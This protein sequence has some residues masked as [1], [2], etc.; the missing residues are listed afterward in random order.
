[1]IERHLDKGRIDLA[2]SKP[3]GYGAEDRQLALAR[4][5]F[6]GGIGLAQKERGTYWAVDEQFG[7][8]LREL[9]ARN[10][11]IAQLYG[12]L[13]NEAGRVERMTGAEA[14]IPVA[15]I[16]I[17][18]GSADEIGDDRFVVLRDGAGQA[19]YGRVRDTEAYRDLRVGSVAE[20][21]AGA[22]RRQQIAE[23]V[24]AV[25]ADKGLYSAEL[26]QAYLRQSQPDATERQI[27]S[28]VRSAESRL[29]FVAG[30]ETSGVRAL[31]G[32]QYAVDVEVFRQ[33]SQ[34]GSERT[35]V[36]VIAEHTLTNQIEA[37]AATWLDRQAFG[38]H[39][40]PRTADHP[41]VQDAIAQRG[42]WLVREGYAQRS[43]GDEAAVQLRG[44]ALRQLESEER[45]SLS[46]RLSQ[47]HGLPVTE[48][49]Q[50]GTVDG[51][52]AGVEHLH[53]GKMAVVVA[54]EGVFISPVR[55]AP[56]AA[57]GSAVTLERTSAQDSTVELAASQTLDLEAGMSLDGP[58]GD[59]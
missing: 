53:A 28:S 20:L 21:G 58:G 23:Q 49:P 6:L 47:K 55:Q 13:G 43:Q 35:D 38:D 41:A 7:R 14:S 24:I 3:I 26:Y 31:D 29:R 44:D 36:R 27:A 18:K 25:A 46:E 59:D 16:V 37:H 32:G 9:G 34:R 17:V 8:S 30:F 33:F 12:S 48:L 19:H 54:E 45:T 57:N 39:P 15:G 56:D 52:Y 2:T 10:D 50:G 11:V 1:M 40:D 51:D 42:D 22:H 5:Q 4:L